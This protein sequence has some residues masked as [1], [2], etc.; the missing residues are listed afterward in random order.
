[1]V[2]VLSGM[3]LWQLFVDSLNGPLTKLSGAREVLR[4]TKL[5][6]ETWIL[7]GVLDA[8]FGLAVRLLLLVPVLIWFGT[9]VRWTMLLVPLG[10]LAMVILGT[11][12][13]LLLT[14]AG[15]LYVDIR[16]GLLLVASFWFF[17]TPIVYQA[18]RAGATAL[19]V[20][21]NP[22]TPLVVSTRAWLTGGRG[23]SVGIVIAIVL[24]ATLLL[25]SVWIVYRLAR[26]HL[27]AVL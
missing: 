2:Y 22:L 21:L 20:K 26:Q 15:I 11:A 10:M 4:R 1:M 9:P 23:A 27:I 17:L 19:L 14:P 13:G 18:P 3:L 12:V 6:H 8:L 16:Q 7:A 25:V 5:P 24:G